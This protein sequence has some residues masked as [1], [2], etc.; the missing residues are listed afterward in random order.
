MSRM[1]LLVM[2]ALTSLPLGGC[3]GSMLKGTLYCIDDG[4]ALPMEIETS[5]G[6]GRMTASH[7]ATGEQFSGTYS[8]IYE[9]GF[10][11]T[12]VASSHSDKRA[13]AS[14]RVTTPG[15][16]GSTNVDVAASGTE[17]T[18]SIST[19]SRAPT[20]A[21]ALATLIG[22]MGTVIEIRM[23]IRPGLRPHGYGDGTDN[24]GRRYQL[25]F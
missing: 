21:S 9:D 12:S 10:R 5:Y 7:P 24:H 23:L 14:V 1:T 2:V 15:R 8:G 17:D 25:Q 11:Q 6:H 18:T 19:T 16:F 20:K 3:A 13:D 22:D 4:T